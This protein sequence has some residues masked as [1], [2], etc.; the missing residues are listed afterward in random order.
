MNIILFKYKIIHLNVVCRIWQQKITIT[1]IFQKVKMGNNF[2]NIFL[3]T[4]S[5][6]PHFITLAFINSLNSGNIYTIFTTTL[7]GIIN[8]EL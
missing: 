7:A 2:V 3:I 4:T 5:S 6:L 8:W 1:L